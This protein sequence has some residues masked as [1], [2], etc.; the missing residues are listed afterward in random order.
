MNNRIPK[1]VQIYLE[2]VE[3]TGKIVTDGGPDGHTVTDMFYRYANKEYMQ[4][5][6]VHIIIFC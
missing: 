5:K 6:L 3:L 4:T 1:L 2:I